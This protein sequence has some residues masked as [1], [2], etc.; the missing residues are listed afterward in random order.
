MGQTE[1][2]NY[3]MSKKILSI[4]C[5]LLLSSCSSVDSTK[6]FDQQQ[7]ANLIKQNHTMKPT[8][9]AIKLA[10]PEKNQWKQ[11]DMS[12]GTVGTP[13]ML[14]PS[15]E[16]RTDWS[17]S[18]R[19]KIL[20]YRNDPDATPEHFAA[21]QISAAKTHCQEAIGEIISP[22]RQSA[23]Y[24]IEM[25]HC[26]EDEDQTQIGKALA[27]KD[28]IYLAYYTAID[29]EVSTAQINKMTRVIDN[30]TLLDMHLM[31]KPMHQG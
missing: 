29:H 16:T 21:L 17:E 24:R 20:A 13:I 15:H 19:T 1:E 10:L 25:H 11:I 31:K 23:R 5:M 8:K 4:A 9:Q 30:A 7:A 28:A 26:L 3:N 12:Y 18:I 2:G 14:I 6:V 27:G 22:N